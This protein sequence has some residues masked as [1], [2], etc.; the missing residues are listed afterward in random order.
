[1]KSGSVATRRAARPDE[2]RCSAQTT[3]PFPQRISSAPQ[4]KAG[5]RS[6]AAMREAPLAF[7]AARRIAPAAAY[8]R[9]DIANGGIVSS[10]YRI[11]R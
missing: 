9:P 6:R 7:A 4:V 8:R 5:T 11:A 1:M 2:T 3:P 10:P